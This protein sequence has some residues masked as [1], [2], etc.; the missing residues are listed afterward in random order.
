M[1]KTG[2]GLLI[3]QLSLVRLMLQEAGT[4]KIVNRFIESLTSG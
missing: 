2:V 1:I 3:R 4:W